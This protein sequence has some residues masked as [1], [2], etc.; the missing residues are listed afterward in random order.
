MPD[1]KFLDEEAAGE[2]LLAR[3]YP[4]RMKEALVEM[5]R[6][7]G[8]L[9]VK[10]GSAVK[11]LLVRHL[12]MPGYAEDSR[13]IVDFV[14]NEVSPRAYVN[15]MS[16]YRP[17]FRAAEFPRIDGLPRTREVAEVRE[18]ARGKGLRLDE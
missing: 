2:Y 4:A 12:V 5:Q 8:D 15:I 18:Y 14:A 17:L 3:D 6:Q 10:K 11:G 1:A 9:L 7:V 13:R 16:Q